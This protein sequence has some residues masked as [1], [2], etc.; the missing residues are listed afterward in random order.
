MD[1]AEMSGVEGARLD[2]LQNI[3]FSSVS[4]YRAGPGDH[5]YF[6]YM[7]FSDLVDVRKRIVVSKLGEAGTELQLLFR[8]C[9]GGR[10]R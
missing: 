9:G 7:R 4:V 2:V 1:T 8:P 3:E 5:R 6:A 10:G